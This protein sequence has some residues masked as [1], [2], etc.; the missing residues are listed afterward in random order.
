MEKLKK[1]VETLY[2]KY[3]QK[4]TELRAAG[5]LTGYQEGLLR[6]RLAEVE[7][8][9]TSVEGQDAHAFLEELICKNYKKDAD[10]IIKRMNEIQ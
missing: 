10:E 8:F 9:R 1:L 5:T 6:N 7:R 3:N 2:E 4:E